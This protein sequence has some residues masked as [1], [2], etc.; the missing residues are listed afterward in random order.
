M[1]TYCCRTDCRHETC[2]R[3]SRLAPKDRDISIADL[4]DNCYLSPEVDDQIYLGAIKRSQSASRG[5]LVAAI[6]YGT[7]H[8]A[9]HCDDV[10]KLI[11]GGGGNCAYCDTIADAIEGVFHA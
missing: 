6:C 1:I 11:C 9:Y 2:L 7:Q 8:T 3:H 10:C 4:N 5:D